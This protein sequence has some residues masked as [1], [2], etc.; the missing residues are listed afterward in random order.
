MNHLVHKLT[1]DMHKSISQTSIT[2]KKGDTKR[3]LYIT[4]TENGKV[5]TVSNSC[6]AVFSAT[7]Y[8]NDILFNDCTIED[9]IIVYEF[10]ELTANIPGMMDCEIKLYGADNGLITSP[11]FSIIV[12]G[13][14]NKDSDVMASDEYS[15]LT[16]AISYVD[17]LKRDMED[18][19]NNSV[20][21]DKLDPN[22]THAVQNK[23]V[24]ETLTTVNYNM[25][26]LSMGVSVLSQKTTPDVNDSD[27]GKLLQVVDGVW[28]AVTIPFAEGVSV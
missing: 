5:Y 1:L 25:T 7:K 11:Q 13:V 16:S 9:G 27:N 26:Q 18:I 3:K 4:L 14:V 23:V 6:T 24:A 17:T 12:E 22:S 15:A 10:T 8:N 19:I 28:E 21:D 2:V 20:I